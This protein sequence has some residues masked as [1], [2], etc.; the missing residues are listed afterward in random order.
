MRNSD[1]ELILDW[2]KAFRFHLTEQDIKDTCEMLKRMVEMKQSGMEEDE[3]LCKILTDGNG[4][5]ET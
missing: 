3:I 5:S 2:S 4:R 1:E